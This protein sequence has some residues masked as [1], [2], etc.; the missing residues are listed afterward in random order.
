MRRRSW[1]T[2]GLAATVSSSNGLEEELSLAGIG[3][4]RLLG[5]PAEDLILFHANIPPRFVRSRFSSGIAL[6]A[7]LQHRCTHVVASAIEVTDLAEAMER[8]SSNEMSLHRSQRRPSIGFRCQG[9]LE[10]A[11]DV[12][13]GSRVKRHGIDKVDTLS[14]ASRCEMNSRR[15]TAVSLHLRQR[16]FRS[17]SVAAS[18][19]SLASTESGVPN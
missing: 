16:R 13:R 14:S 18:R 6:P 11:H 1:E 5:R 17:G 3:A 15:F 19:S 7:R 9:C 8:R 12:D 4:T 10:E 2:T